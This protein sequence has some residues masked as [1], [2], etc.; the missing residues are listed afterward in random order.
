MLRAPANRVDKCKRARGSVPGMVHAFT[1]QR[2]N[3]D[4]GCLGL[5]MYTLPQPAILRHS[6]TDNGQMAG[7]NT[8]I[9]SE[10][11]H[12]PETREAVTT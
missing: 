9:V 5:S 4:P 1:S 10:W 3:P 7:I 6:A 2:D 11:R 8:L 12:S